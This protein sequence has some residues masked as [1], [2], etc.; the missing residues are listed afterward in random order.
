VGELRSIVTDP[1]E[2]AKGTAIADDGGLMHLSRHENKL[3]ADAAGSGATP[4]KTQI[5]LG[6]DKV[7]GRCSCMAARS[8]P[9]CK[10]A[11]A[12]LVSWARTPEAFAVAETPPFVAEAR[13]KRAAVKRAN[14]DPAELRKKGVEQAG[15]LLVELWQ[16]GVDALAADRAGQVADLASSLRELGLRRLS[17]RTLDL[18]ELL[19]AAARRDGSFSAEAYAGLVSDMWLTVKKLEK[20]LGG[21]PLADEHVEEL[22]GRTWTKKDRKPVAGLDLIEYAFLQRTTADDFVLRESRLFD[23]A[24]GEHYSEKQ[25]LPAMIARRATP[26]P[27][28]AGLRLESASGS[29][30]PSF[31]PRRIDLDQQGARSELDGA[32]LELALTRALPDVTRALALLA[33]RRRD[34]FAPP[35]VPVLVRIDTVVP[36]RDRILF[37]D[38]VGGALY[39][40]GGRGQENA[41]EAALASVSAVALFGDVRLDGALPSLFPHALLGRDG[42]ASSV[43]GRERPQTPGSCGALRLLPLGGDDDPSDDEE[44]TA[45]ARRAE[46]AARDKVATAAVLLGEVRADLAAGFQEG[47]VGAASA[48]FVA[49]LAARLVE[50]KLDKQAEALR[51]MSMAGDPAASLDAFVKVY[52]LLGIAL[53]RVSS[54]ARLDRAALT[55]LPTMPSV[56]IPRPVA[57]LTPEAAVAAEAR[58]EIHRFERAYHVATHYALVSAAELLADAHRYWGDGDAVP[59]VLAAAQADPAAARDRAGAVLSAGR[60]SVW[61]PTPARLAKL[62]AIRVLGADEHPAAKRAL[63]RV[64]PKT[65]DP[66]LVAFAA[67]AL[68]GP[69]LAKEKLDEHAA[70]VTGGSSKDDRIR[71]IDLLVRGAAIEGIPVLRAALRDRTAAVRKAAAYGLAALGDAIALHTFVSWLGSDDHEQAKVGAH[72]L[73][74][75]GDV[76]GAG[77][78]LA[79]L[80]RGFSPVVVREA[81]ALLGPWVLGPLLDLV[82]AQPELA[83]RASVASLV[84]AFPAEHSG[85]TI[86]AW[87]AAGAHSPETLH[88]RA[89]LAF[90]FA[91]QR[92]DVAKGIAEWCRASGAF[93]GDDRERRAMRKKIEAALAPKDAYS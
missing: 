84:K 83:K 4:Y 49:P 67:R 2:L 80:A 38:E 43:W 32:T 52:Q 30:F 77:A 40:G 6:D 26:K 28:Y 92:P 11:A 63:D 87:L 17:G 12:L 53:A 74:Q 5:V 62:T 61:H 47:A 8:R 60:T 71:A 78:L 65:H 66:G 20:H 50:L 22:I 23:I 88:A 24:A 51:G 33:E 59:F 93:E 79:A 29:M 31:P 81:L 25:I 7:T 44:A 76:R 14:V 89:K 86:A 27:S 82:A 56:A 16:T 15:T 70:M 45:R 73:G 75:L 55:P 90:E 48:R 68:T 34:V 9:F 36:S 58:G 3:F 37:V 54:V 91:S 1:S 13:G 10:H 21:E 57:A 39:L 72:A 19:G 18:A 42:G 35:S 64:G 85:G 69:L 41:L 46:A